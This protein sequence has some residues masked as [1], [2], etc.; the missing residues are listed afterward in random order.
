MDLAKYGRAFRAALAETR[1]EY[2]DEREAKDHASAIATAVV[3]G[4]EIRD[5]RAAR[6]ARRAAEG[7]R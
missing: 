2:A 3:F 1:R 5:S 4:H 6:A 7:A